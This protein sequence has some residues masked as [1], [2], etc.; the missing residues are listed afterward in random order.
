[1][2]IEAISQSSA[3]QR[4]GRCGRTANGMCIRLYDEKDFLS[5]PEYTEPEIQRSNLADVILRMLNL[6]LG[7]IDDFPFVDPPPKQSIDGGFQLLQ[8]LGA[9]DSKKNLTKR[10]QSRAR[11]P[12]DPTVSRMILQAR[13]E[14]VLEETLIIAAALSVQDPRER[15]TDARENP[16]FLHC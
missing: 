6:H 13:N 15:P 3:E 12:I 2:P 16:Y 5:R 8:Q 9:I 11:L 1:M 7:S 14:K 4:K 10:G